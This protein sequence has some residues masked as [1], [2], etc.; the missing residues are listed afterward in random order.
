[1]SLES[2]LQNDWLTREES[3]VAEIQKPL[4]VVDRERGDARVRGLSPD[5][6]FEHAYD[7]AL[8]LCL[9]AL[10]AAGFRPKKGGGHH[11]R[12]LESLRFTLGSQW[13][14]TADYLS[15]CNRLR[16]QVVY[17]HVDV[18]TREDAAELIDLA[19]ELRSDVIT[20]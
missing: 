6:Q 19:D 20:G 3:S 11:V 10:R 16:G 9:V 12:G 1:V 5:G 13:K 8:Q 7:A 15:R 4:Q 17:D 2:W 18:A 14:N